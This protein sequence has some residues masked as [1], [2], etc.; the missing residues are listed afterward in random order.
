MITPHTM[1]DYEPNHENKLSLVIRRVQEGKTSICINKI[2]NEPTRVH[3][4]LTMNTLSAGMQFF[5]RLETDVRPQHI[6]VINS[7][8]STAGNCHHAKNESSARK[9]LT[10]EH[11]KVIV[12]CAHE[13]RFRD[14]IPELLDACADSMTLRSIQFSIHIDEAHAYINSYREE[15]RRF[16]DMKNVVS[17]IGYTGSPNPIWDPKG[18]DPL[19]GRIVVYDTESVC[20]EF[21]FGVKDTI[22]KTF[23]HIAPGQFISEAQI[24]DDIP[25][26]V[27]RRSETPRV[28]AASSS[29]AKVEKK[30]T[31]WYEDKYPFQ[32]GNERLYLAFTDHILRTELLPTIPQDEFSYHFIPSY[33][34]KVTQYF[35]VD[36][37]LKYFPRSNVIV[38]NGNGMEFYRMKDDKSFQF[39]KIVNGYFMVSE[40]SDKSKPRMLEPSKQIQALIEGF[41]NVP[42]FVTGLDCVGMSV[43]LINDDIGNF[44]TVVLGHDQLNSEQRYQLC[45]FVFN[46]GRWV[47]K[48]KVKRT[49]LLSLTKNVVD[50]C[51]EYEQEVVTICKDFQGSNPTIR[52]ILGLE[53][54]VPTEKE[55][56]K[57]DMLMLGDFLVNPDPKNQWKRFKVMDGN[58]EEEWTKAKDHYLKVRGNILKGKSMPKKNDDGFY[59]CSTTSNKKKGCQVRTEKE[60]DHIRLDGKFR[61]SS[62]FQLNK[63]QLRYARVFVGYTNEDD[64]TEYTIY[65]KHAQLRDEPQV[66]TLLEKIHNSK[67]SKQ[68]I[69]SVSSAA[70]AA[71]AAAASF[72]EESDSFTDLDDS[73]SDLDDIDIS[74]DSSSD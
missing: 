17:I 14:S 64:P 34:R 9:I 72:S 10:K 68:K 49:Q 63:G 60:I 58:D 54:Y 52:E 18:N 4:I 28:A 56:Q 33:K 53:P 66:R 2:V 23:E 48:S 50:T 27:L 15:V 44:D 31:T 11:I 1:S 73:S 71:A 43:T 39:R 29:G 35:M 70:A 69:A 30:R 67:K 40:K 65:I 6:L 74:S 25:E 62:L 24:V 38:M 55:V 41:E 13:K 19:F 20:S 8:P 7:N 36:L 61:W 57:K 3:I 21:Y 12:C 46:Y 51:L 42:T 59:K 26:H 37:F 16:N 47:D 22:Q 5:G 45:R 32:C